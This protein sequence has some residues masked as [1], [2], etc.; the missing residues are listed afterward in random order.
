MA[1]VME[2]LTYHLRPRVQSFTLAISAAANSSGPTAMFADMTVLIGEQ[3]SQWDS[4]Y[5]K[6]VDTTHEE[7]RN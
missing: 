2:Y 3:R 1:L 7:G 4:N 6:P 5:P